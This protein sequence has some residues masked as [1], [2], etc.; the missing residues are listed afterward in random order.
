MRLCINDSKILARI[1]VEGNTL[2]HPNRLP[3]SLAFSVIES[4]ICLAIHV[5]KLTHGDTKE[6]VAYFLSQGRLEILLKLDYL[7]KLQ[8]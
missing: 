6:M 2:H 1:R 4:D 5:K 7:T 3:V 8:S